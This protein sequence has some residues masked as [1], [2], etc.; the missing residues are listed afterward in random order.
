MAGADPVSTG[1]QYEVPVKLYGGMLPSLFAAV[2]GKNLRASPS[3]GTRVDG[4]LI[5][6]DRVA[7]PA[8]RKI[9]V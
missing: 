8:W 7:S 1:S 9:I 4:S 3:F 5:V 2:T 6:N